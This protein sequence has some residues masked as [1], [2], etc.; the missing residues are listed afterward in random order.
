MN[1]IIVG[2]GRIGADLALR[3]Y[4]QGHQVTIIDNVPQAF[5]R[6]NP[7]FQGRTVEGEAL[8]KEV[9]E[10]AGIEKADGLAAVA[11]SDTLNAAVAHIARTIYKIANVVVRNYD[12]TL[13]PVLEAF[14][15]QIV[16]STAWGAQRTEELLSTTSTRAVFSPGN[17][18]VEIYEI[19][20]PEG[21]NGRVLNDLLCGVDS[22]L[23]VAITHVGCSS[24]PTQDTILQSGDVLTISATAEG[25]ACLR[26]ALDKKEA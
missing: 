10:R 14:G 26:K 4:K 22:C 5:E 18:E 15:L 16:S 3:L 11:N 23:P 6:L 13:R 20:V 25:I 19:M 7:E 1:F 24:L 8:S 12:P 21:W 17:G 2:C 9:L